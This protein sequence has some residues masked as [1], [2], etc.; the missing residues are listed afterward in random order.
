MSVTA[1]APQAVDQAFVEEFAVRWGEAWNSHQPDRLLALMAE[2]IV[3]D[4]SAWPTTMRG[5]GEVRA[6]LEAT[7]RA[8]GDLT[9]ELVDGPFLHPEAPRTTYHWRGVATHTGPIEPPGFAPTGKRIEFQGFDLHE[10]KEGVVSRLLIVFDMADIGRQIGLLPASGSFG[11]RALV[12]AQR[13]R[14]RLPRRQRV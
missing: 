4:D 13:M 9:F 12:A 6:F 11:E 1:S 8:F 7:W 3:Y 5:H 10:Y 14:A 2:D